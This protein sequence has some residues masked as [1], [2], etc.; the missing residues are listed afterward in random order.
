MPLLGNNDINL[1]SLILRDLW[2]SVI[3]IV[4]ICMLFLW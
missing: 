1:V 3:F 2:S 4:C